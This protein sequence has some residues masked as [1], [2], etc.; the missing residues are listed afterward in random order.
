MVE[1]K[2]FA[3]ATLD[4]KYKT[5]VIYIA[6]IN[7]L[8]NNLKNNIHPSYKIQIAALIAN[9]ALILIFTKYYNFGNIFYL[10]L[11]FK[12]FKYTGINNY[13]IN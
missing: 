11:T 12:L 9:K 5:F 2:E 4:L 10:K 8:S 3:A 7:N 13:V 1:K 6:Y